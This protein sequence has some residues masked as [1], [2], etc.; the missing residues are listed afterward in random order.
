[1]IGFLFTVSTFT[2]Y[3]MCIIVIC[4]QHLPSLLTVCALDKQLIYSGLAY[5][6]FYTIYLITKGQ[7]YSVVSKN[8]YVTMLNHSCAVH[9]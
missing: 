2:Y 5:K 9:N 7:V 4:C 8:D 6:N 3:V 1:M